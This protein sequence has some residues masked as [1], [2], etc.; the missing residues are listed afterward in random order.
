MATRSPSRTFKFRSFISFLITLAFLVAVFSGVMLYVTPQGRMAHWT[1][2]RLLGYD[3]DQWTALHI[4]MCLLF[5]IGSGVHIY[6]NWRVLWSYVTTKATAGFRRRWEFV[7]AL[8]LSVA[9]ILGT[10]WLLPPLGSIIR[11]NEDI[12]AY[13]GSTVTT[14]APVP[15]AEALPIK[16]LAQY[17]NDATPQRIVQY[18]RGAGYD[19]PDASVTLE[20]L[21]AQ[22]DR[23]PMAVYD[24]IRK[25]MEP[26]ADAG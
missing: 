25:G 23:S 21:G 2:W 11:F 9:F 5:L 26:A 19:V 1:G 12:K 4:N 3:K 22:R 18:L 8:G 6:L 7:S 14:K 20:S 16:K 17:L 13:W 10:H 24:E 15:H